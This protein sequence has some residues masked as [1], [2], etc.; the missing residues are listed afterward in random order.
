MIPALSALAGLCPI[1]WA[2]FVQIEH[3]EDACWKVSTEPI[4]KKIGI[5]C[6][7]DFITQMYMITEKGITWFS[8]GFQVFLIRLLSIILTV[9][10]PIMTELTKEIECMAALLKR[11]DASTLVFD[12]LQAVEA[13]LHESPIAQV[14]QTYRKSIGSEPLDEPEREQY[15]ERKRH[16]ADQINRVAEELWRELDRVKR[17]RQ[18]LSL[19]ALDPIIREARAII[20]RVHGLT[21]D[22]E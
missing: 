13:G 21:A 17:I 18:T 11:V 5:Q 1:C 3:W 10:F 8:P 14:I 20:H 16:E 7:I 15:R 4:N 22:L 6:F 9:E 12:N 19:E 2:V